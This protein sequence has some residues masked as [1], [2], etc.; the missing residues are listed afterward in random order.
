[1]I[2]NLIGIIIVAIIVICAVIYGFTSSGS[3]TAARAEKFDTQ[4]VSDL[5]SI[6]YSINS[7]Y[8]INKVLPPTIQDAQKVNGYNTVLTDPETKSNYEYIPGVDNAYKLC[9]VFSEK[10]PQENNFANARYNA[11]PEFSTHPKGSYCFELTAPLPP[12][13]SAPIYK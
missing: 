5:S 3:P 2:K 8:S 6:M 10:Q 11:Y 12:A 1:M 4:R 9:A 13:I 7:Y